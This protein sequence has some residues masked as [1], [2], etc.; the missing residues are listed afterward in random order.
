MT[1]RL[2]DDRYEILRVL[3]TGGFGVVHYG[4]DREAQRPVAIKELSPG[5]LGAPDIVEMFLDE[6]R[7]TRNLLHPKVVTVHELRQDATGGVYLVMEYLDGMDL[8]TILERLAA[9]RKRLPGH[10][11]LHIIAEVLDALDYAHRFTDPESGAPAHIVHRDISP[12][13]IIIL[14]GG[15]VKLIDFGIAKAQHRLA[16][17][18]KSGVLKGRLSYVSP[19]QLAAT[20]RVP[21]DARSDLF[22]AGAVL[23]EMCV[24]RRAFDNVNEFQLMR[25]VAGGQY[26]RAALI[27]AALPDGVVRIIE[28]ALRVDPSQRFPNAAVMRDEAQ[29][30]AHELGAR[31]TATV[32]SQIV[33][34]LTTEAENEQRRSLLMLRGGTRVP[35][36]RISTTPIRSL[37]SLPPH[38]AKGGEDHRTEPPTLDRTQIGIVVARRGESEGR[39]TVPPPTRPKRTVGFVMAGLAGF[40]LAAD[41]LFG[42]PVSGLLGRSAGPIPDVDESRG[43][44]ATMPAGAKVKLNG[45]E[46]GFSPC[47][48]PPIGPGAVTL[49]IE[50]AGFEPIDTVIHIEDGLPRLSLFPLRAR[51]HFRSIPEGARVWIDG[52]E[53]SEFEAANWRIAVNDTVEL[54]LALDR[55]T[56][57]PVARFTLLEGLIPPTDTSRWRWQAPA[58][59]LP[60]EI[61]GLFARPVRIHSRPPGASVYVD[62]DSVARGVTD[63]ALDLTYGDHAIV[64]RRE[65]FL[66]YGFQINVGTAT[67]DLY[68]P[69][70]KRTVQI[71]ATDR[72]SPSIDLAAGIEWIRQGQV[73]IKTPRDNLQT[74]YSMA[75]GGVEHEI[76]LRHSG[77]RDTTVRL[78]PETDRLIIAMTPVAVLSPDRKGSLAAETDEEGSLDLAWVQ[79]IVRDR[80]GPVAG[81]EVIGIEKTT[82]IVVRYGVTD[83]EGEIFTRVPIG[84]Y[85]WEAS[86][87]GYEGR[88]NSERISPRRD[89][90]KITLRLNRLSQ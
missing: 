88:A 41:F 11:A 37:P 69:V 55:G 52:R 67:P 65:P 79:F 84:N 21:V 85:N 27:A 38:P 50:A 35:V 78:G 30:V 68:A 53:I 89:F 40:Y 54:M 16:Q 70:L 23:Y 42:G 72:M 1:H 64:L 24:G 34:A 90:K 6:A 58:G 81:A 4:W 44:V 73:Y 59:G 83:E 62:G 19:E 18:T 39:G 71:R 26:D 20:G 51:V 60:G 25:D 75:L 36:Q 77:Y 33:A 32:L 74:P 80:S 10:L 61:T 31:N 56:T 47:R 63:M 2:I 12:P 87:A 5:H 82:G 8:E 14:T 66:D 57:T 45:E 48:L 86:K 28:C 7:I 3:S 15:G 49:Q 13:N 17:K 46:I 29:R 43:I 22:S 9:R 76:H